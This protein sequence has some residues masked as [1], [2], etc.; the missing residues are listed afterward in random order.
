MDAIKR[1]ARDALLAAGTAAGS[2]ATLGA[3]TGLD[4]AAIYTVATAAGAAGLAVIYDSVAPLAASWQDRIRGW[5]SRNR[6]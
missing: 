5:I 3:F 4:V 1:T 2:T 6:V